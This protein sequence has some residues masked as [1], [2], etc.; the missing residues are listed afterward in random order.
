MS[1]VFLFFSRYG[2]CSHASLTTCADELRAAVKMAHSSPRETCLVTPSTRQK[3]SVP[4]LP[5]PDQ[6]PLVQSLD[7]D[8]HVR[9]LDTRHPGRPLTARRAHDG[10]GGRKAE[11]APVKRRSVRS[12]E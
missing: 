3:Q 12:R 9:A 10:E 8:E 2:P 5:F 11:L 4:H 6:A 1:S 7:E